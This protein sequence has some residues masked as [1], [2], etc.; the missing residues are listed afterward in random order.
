LTKIDLERWMML[1]IK[2]KQPG[3]T[4]WLLVLLPIIDQEV[5]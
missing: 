4:P 1:D 3:K 5:I 2:N